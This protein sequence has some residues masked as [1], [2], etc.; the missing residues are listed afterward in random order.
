MGLD[1]AIAVRGLE[2]QYGD[3]TAV[4]S[5]D[6]TV[7]R[8]DVFG[9]L[10]PNGPGK[11][12]TVEI[13]EG[14]RERSGGEVSVLG[15]DPGR[16]PA[17]LRRLVGIVL[18]STGIYRHITVKEALAHFAGL[19]PHPRDVDEV[20]ALVGL[21]EKQ[22]VRAR[23]LSGAQLR[24]LALALAVVVDPELIFF[25][26]PTTGFDLAAPRASWKTIRQ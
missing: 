15:F 14:Y 25:S 20:I 16:R 22:D 23:N 19:Y 5:V 24:R 18:Q 2:K 21:E 3:L 8:G 26:K 1:P 7:A 4:A 10:G 11:T 17:D 13:L 9:L 6:F 12:T